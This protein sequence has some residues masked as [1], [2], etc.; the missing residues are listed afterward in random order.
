MPSE[1]C[2]PE[3]SVRPGSFSYRKS[4]CA[5]FS[6]FSAGNWYGH[7]LRAALRVLVDMPQRSLNS[8]MGSSEIVMAH[9]GPNLF[10]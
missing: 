10:T 7:I 9:P 2:A 1:S 8:M 3:I 6:G 4:I 5:S